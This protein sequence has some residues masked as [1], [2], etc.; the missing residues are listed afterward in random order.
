MVSPY[1]ILVVDDDRTTR[2]T[3]TAYF[4]ASGYRVSEAGDGAALME[5]LAKGPVDL[6]L[7]DVSLPGED[8]FALLREIRRTSDIAVIMVSGKTDA[9]DRI[10]GLELGAHDY[11][12]KPFNTRELLARAKNLIRLTRAVP[13]APAHDDVIRF[14]DWTIDRTARRLIAPSG[15]DVPLTRA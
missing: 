14:E 13:G 7:L 1:H 6:I 15:E 5:C 11:V 12:T 10:V 8:G 2:M 3:L 4:E 9:L